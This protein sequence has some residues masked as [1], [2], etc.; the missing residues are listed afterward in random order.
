MTVQIFMITVGEESTFLTIESLKANTT[1]DYKLTIW[2]DVCGRNFEPAFL[3]R[4][5]TY[6]N[7]VVVSFEQHG[8]FSETGWF[9]LYAK[10]DFLI[11]CGA[12]TP[13]KPG[14]FDRLMYPFTQQPNL[15]ICG[16]ANRYIPVAYDL[17]GHHPDGICLLSS[18]MLGKVGSIC[19]SFTN[20]GPYIVEFLDRIR[21]LGFDFAAVQDVSLHLGHEGR[22]KLSNWREMLDTDCKVLL[23]SQALAGQGYNWFDKHLMEKELI[24]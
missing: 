23:K 12:D 3:E 21:R 6:T 7:D 17:N 1:V 4:L 14:Y 10:A 8:A 13:A 2:Y 18:R 24:A 5:R 19:S 15:V 16:E 9:L 22:E 20:I 11:L